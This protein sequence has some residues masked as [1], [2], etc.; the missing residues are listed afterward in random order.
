MGCI[1]YELA[2]TVF[3]SLLLVQH[4]VKDAGQGCGFCA[5]RGDGNSLLAVSGKDRLR[6]AF[7]AGD[8]AKPKTFNPE[9]GGEEDDGGDGAG[10]ENRGAEIGDGGVD[11]AHVHGDE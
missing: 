4:G 10:Y 8:G 7:H 11:L 1:G 3:D 5:C 2:E 9:S 6:G